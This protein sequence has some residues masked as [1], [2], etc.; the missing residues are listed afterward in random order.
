MSSLG[1]I[2]LSGIVAGFAAAAI[3]VTAGAGLWWALLAYIV[4]GDIGLIATAL[5]VGRQRDLSD[6]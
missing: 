5:L 3:A 1:L 6:A 2:L 4:G